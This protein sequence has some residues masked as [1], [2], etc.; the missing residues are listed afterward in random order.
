M[1]DTARVLAR[2]YDGI[3]YRGFGRGLHLTS[4]QLATAAAQEGMGVA[5]ADSTLSS[6]EITDAEFEGILDQLHG[7]GRYRLPIGR[8]GDYDQKLVATQARRHRAPA[9]MLAQAFGGEHEQLISYGMTK[10][11]V[12][13]LEVVQV[14]E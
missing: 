1:R 11:V 9:E 12:H 2:M 13:P 4:N 3:E 14:E 8:V 7:D 10:A 6:D 5:L